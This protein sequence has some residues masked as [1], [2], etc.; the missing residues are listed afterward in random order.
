MLGRLLR[1]PRIAEGSVFPD[2]FGKAAFD[3]N[4]ST[5]CK[6]KRMRAI[7]HSSNKGRKAYVS[8]ALR[9]LSE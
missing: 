7:P 9:H 1:P 4:F 8:M 6:R 5:N 3:F 2:F